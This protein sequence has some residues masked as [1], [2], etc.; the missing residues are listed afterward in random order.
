MPLPLQNSTTTVSH[1]SMCDPC[2]IPLLLSS[3]LWANSVHITHNS[4]YI[5]CVKI[6]PGCTWC[7][8]CSRDSPLHGEVNVKF[9][10]MAKRVLNDDSDSHELN[11]YQSS[12][13]SFWPPFSRI[14]LPV[15]PA[16]PESKSP[17]SH[18]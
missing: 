17:H 5:E 16:I 10:I 14:K 1:L 15:L 11:L 18:P 2:M 6:K 12:F 9:L 7:S 4:G 8:E 13:P 3:L